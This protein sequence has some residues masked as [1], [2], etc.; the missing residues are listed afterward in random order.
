MTKTWYPVINYENC[1]ECGVC[2]N[3][4]TH[5]VYQ[6]DSEKPK[7]MYPEECVNQCRGCQALCPA[8]AITYFSST[9]G[10]KTVYG[11]SCGSF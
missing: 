2:T 7:V 9:G 6:K 11:C 8:E 3:T 10:N 1:T 4:C 5:G